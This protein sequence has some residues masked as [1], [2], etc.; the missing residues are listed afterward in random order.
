MFLSLRNQIFP[1]IDVRVRIGVDVETFVDEE[2]GVLS[3]KQTSLKAYE[4]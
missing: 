2:S 1:H 4:A 3:S